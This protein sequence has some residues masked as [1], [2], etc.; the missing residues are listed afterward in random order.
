MSRYALR[1]LITA[2]HRLIILGFIMLPLLAALPQLSFGQSIVARQADFL[3]QEIIDIEMGASSAWLLERIKNSGTHSSGPLARPNRTKI[4][5]VPSGNRY[6]GQLD[7]NFTEKDRLY[8]I[9]L[10]VNDDS[11]WNINSLKK[12]FLERFHISTDDPSRF[13]I[14]DDD[15]IVYRPGTNGQSHFFEV[16]D[17]NTGKKSLELFDK[18]IDTKDRVPSGPVNQ[19][20]DK[21]EPK[22]NAPAG[23]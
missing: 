8:L 14:R 22:N 16:T 4:S 18:G 10:L 9:R 5:W 1:L 6:Y 23:Q 11:R 2:R 3:P 7:F 13:R 12:Q 21:Q 15:T 17:V 20:A 19:S